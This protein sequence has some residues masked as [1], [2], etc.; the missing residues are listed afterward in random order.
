M[1]IKRLIQ[2]IFFTLIIQYLIHV[3]NAQASLFDGFQRNNVTSR[4]FVGFKGGINFSQPLILQSY[5]V[6]SQVSGLNTGNEAKTYSGFLKNTG[7]QYHFIGMYNINNNLSISF[8]PGVAQYS[9][10]YE[11]DYSWITEGD[12]INTITLNYS[13]KQNLRYIEIPVLFRFEY[14]IGNIS[15]YIQGGISYGILQQADKSVSSELI[16]HSLSGDIPLNVE[17][18]ESVVSDLFIRSR[19]ALLG[20]IGINYNLNGVLL[21]LE[22]VYNAGLNN[23]VNESRRF[24]NQDFLSGN[25]DV[26][27]DINLQNLMINFVVLFPLNKGTNQKDDS[28]KL[29]LKKK[30]K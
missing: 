22:A 15:P 17:D 16:Q 2:S 14:A 13:H 12:D 30:N 5:S 25:Y 11:N 8:Q 26:P 21:G 9:Y 7:Y 1:N 4:F 6:F 24:S 3:E 27:D 10:S 20:G 28:C 29:F 23:I 19:L 18:N